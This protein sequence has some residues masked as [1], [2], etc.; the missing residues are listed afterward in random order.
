MCSEVNLLTFIN[1]VP[2]SSHWLPQLDKT[3]E[4][5]MCHILLYFRV[6]VPILFS[7]WTII[8]LPTYFLG[9]FSQLQLNINSDYLNKMIFQK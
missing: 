9:C 4:N 2:C 7:P 1:N 3:S 8:I 6:V 5:N